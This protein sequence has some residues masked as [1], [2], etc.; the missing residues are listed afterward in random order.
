MLR[1]TV[2][3]RTGGR[4][5]LLDSMSQAERDDAGEVLVAASNGGTESG[6]IAVLARCAAVFFNDA[7][8]GK[9]EA[10]VAG[11]ALLDAAGIP[12]GAVGHL[13]ARISDGRDTWENGVLTHVNRTAEA[14]GL[15]VGDTVQDAVARLREEGPR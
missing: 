8:V 13:T 15:T 4:V 11:L 3:D 6:R 9:D 12:G 7:G 5:Q 2:E 14:A 10:G 1:Q